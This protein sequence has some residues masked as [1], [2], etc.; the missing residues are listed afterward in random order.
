MFPKEARPEQLIRS[1]GDQPGLNG[2]LLFA[3][4]AERLSWFYDAD[5]WP[6]EGAMRQ[7]A[8][9]WLERARIRLDSARLRELVSASSELA[10]AAA[11]QLSRQAGLQTAHE[12]RESLDPN[13]HSPIGEAMMAQCIAWLEASGE[14]VEGSDKQQ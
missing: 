10:Q 11:A 9:G 8:L 12:M 4:V 5:Q 13:Y 6:T 7:Q 2:A 1:I 14:A 3:L